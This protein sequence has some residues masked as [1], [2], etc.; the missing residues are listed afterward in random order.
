[1]P[2]P[3]VAQVFPPPVYKVDTMSEPRDLFYCFPLM[4]GEDVRA[5]Q[6]ALTTLGV[7]PPCGTSDGI[8]GNAT[9]LSVEAFQRSVRDLIVDGVVGRLTHDALFGKAIAAFPEPKTGIAPAQWSPPDVSSLIRSTASKP[10]LRRDQALQCR[11][12][13]MQHFGSEIEKAVSGTPFDALLIC[14]IAAKETA[15]IW[16]NWINQMSAD[17]IVARCVFDASGDAPGTSRNAFPA[18]TAIFRKK[19]G[20][21]VTAEFID[22]ANRTRAIRKMGPKDWV[23]KGYGIFQYDLQHILTD[24]SFFLNKQ[25]R[26]FPS[27][28]ARVMSEL[29]LKHQS[30][31]GDLRETIRLYNGKGERAQIYAD[32]VLIMYDWMKKN[33]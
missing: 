33:S 13:L 26:D 11:D 12:W 25:W 15:P 29:K 20:D 14:A 32:H 30:A 31:G 1:M 7:Q 17:E 3:S 22:E 5:V 27:C 16:L 23:Y 2:L 21:Q 9:R 10:P 18:N 6:K 19:Y 28:L 24:P 4:R 8:F